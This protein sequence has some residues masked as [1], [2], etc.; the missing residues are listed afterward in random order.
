ME[1]KTSPLSDLS[2]NQI[3]FLH[4]HK[5]GEDQLQIALAVDAEARRQ[6]VNPEFVWP[7]VYQ[8]SKFQQDATSPR[9][10]IGVMQLMPDTAKGLKVD[11]ADLNQN[12]SGGISLLKELMANPKIGNDPYKVLAGYNASTDTRNKFYESGDLADLKDETIKH[13]YQV[14][15][16]YGGELPSV[17]IE[18][19]TPSEPDQVATDVTAPNDGNVYSGTPV[20]EY[21]QGAA[22]A[23]LEAAALSGLTGA[24]LG[25]VYSAKAPAVRMAQRVGLLPGGKPIS[26]TEAAE[27]VEKTMSANAPEAA[28]KPLHGGEKWQRSL[29]GIS[30]PGAQMD[31]TSLDLA[32]GMQSAVGVHGAPGFTGGTITEGG[33]I[34][35][36]Q[37]AAAVRAKQAALTP[38]PMAPQK[39]PSFVQT[40][41]QKVAGS[42]PVRGGL[43]GLGVGYNVQ[44]AANKF[45]EG[46]LLS[47]A[48]SSSAAGTSAASLFPKLTS[49]MNP[50]TV[51]L[52][53]ASQVAGDLRRGDKQAAAESGLTGLATLLPR[54]FGPAGAALYSSG[55]NKDEM[56]ELERRRMMQPT[57]TR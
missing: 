30:T 40:A 53:T 29:T 32:K 5:L 21:K 12:I 45:N 57:I 37:E 33:I 26:A 11:A 16:H 17:S 31:K 15:K 2:D 10:A 25:T 34:L 50:L 24:G 19:K 43:A 54:L 41:A 44:D 49:R 20:T 48:L 52:T 7:M 28:A 39:Q 38:P 4:K 56:Q 8:E 6:G 42:A 46:D 55:L 22:S 51:G 13:M 1:L 27:L 9:G 3:K 47:G 23:P 14:G 36:P 35:S 18:P